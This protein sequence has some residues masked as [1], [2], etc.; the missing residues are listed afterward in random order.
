MTLY[1]LAGQAAAR[2][3]RELKGSGI[4]RSSPSGY[5]TDPQL[6]LIPGVMPED[7]EV[8]LQHGDG[9]ELTD[10]GGEAAKFCAAYSSSALGV[11]SFGPFRRFPD[12]LL[13]SGLS[14][15]EEAQFE[16]K[17]P[18]GL[19]GNAPNLDFLARGSHAVIGVE[20]KFLEPLGS[21]TTGF[22]DSYKALVDSEADDRWRHAYE[23]LAAVPK[24]FR[25]LDAVQLVKH[26][27][28]LRH[29]FSDVP[30]LALLYV[31]WEPTNS[32]QH[33]E[34]AAHRDE[35]SQFTEWREGADVR[36]EALAYSALWQQWEE[37]ATWD[38]IGAHVSA[39]RGR[40]A[41]DV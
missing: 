28:G 31:F 21:K 12:R 14:S 35:V 41:F 39:L 18:T 9:S 20:S 11:N 2:R 10:R 36:F 37:N 30:E 23:T 26:S 3:L 22:A 16:C 40:Y 8:D 17:C 4:F 1:E 33:R 27:L 38:G 13:L 34:F 25:Y 7:F 19:K 24:T 32:D 29:T 6:N 15:F 5:T